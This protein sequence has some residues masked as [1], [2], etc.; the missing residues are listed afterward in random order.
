[1][2]NILIMF[3]NRPGE[4]FLGAASRVMAHCV[5]CKAFWSEDEVVRGTMTGEAFA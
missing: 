5:L 3:K 1:M 2:F 4:N